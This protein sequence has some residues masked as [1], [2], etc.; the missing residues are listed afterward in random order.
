M[1]SPKPLPLT[2]SPKARQDFF[3]ILRY[4]GETWGQNQLLQELIAAG[5]RQL[6]FSRRLTATSRAR[7]EFQRVNVETLA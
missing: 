7:F 2:L 6:R 5:V 1:S 3:D 4:T